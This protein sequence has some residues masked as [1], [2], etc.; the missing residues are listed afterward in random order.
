MLY[1]LPGHRGTVNDMRFSPNVAE[2]ISKITFL[3][4][5]D[6]EVLMDDNCSRLGF[7]R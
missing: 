7:F 2:P 3:M 4:I 5:N 6:T 1:K